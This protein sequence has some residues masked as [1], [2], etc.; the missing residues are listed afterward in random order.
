VS[1]DLA[2]VSVVI[3]SWNT[4]ELLDACLRSLARERGP[5][6]EIVVVDNG[7]TD[8]SPDH[9]ARAFPSVVLVRN[10]RNEG[11]A[12]ASNQGLRLARGRHVLLLNSDTEVLDDALERM[13]AFLDAHPRYGAVAPRLV[14][15]D[16]RTQ[17]TVQ[18][19]PNLWTPLFFGTPLERWFPR[20]RELERYFLRGWDQES[21]ADVEQPPAACLLVR[22]EV[23]ERVGPFDEEL[24][25]FFNDVDLSRR[26]RAAGFETR[27]L[28]EARVLHHV[29]AST[30]KF[31]G[32]VSEWQRNRLAYYRKHHGR[33]AGAWV[34]LCA[35][36]AFADW[37]ARQLALR[38]RR[39]AAEP[40]G[41]T[42]RLFLAY[43]R[44]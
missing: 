21:S 6:L 4:R 40:I 34:K 23:L 9:V 28:A 42:A 7:S 18:A 27:Y 1:A 14:H 16:G 10:E 20:S 17:R 3:P 39:R 33:A 8:G 25:L 41:P 11:F 19:F 13:V 30:A 12:R 36:L 29:G 22:R 2:D 44:S 5:R 37:A 15:P 43:L 38:M 24:W 35:S 26:M 31:A 32:F